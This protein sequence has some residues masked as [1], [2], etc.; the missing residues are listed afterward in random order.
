MRNRGRLTPIKEAPYKTS[1]L[2]VAITV[3]PE[4]RR[5]HQGVYPL[6]TESLVKELRAVDVPA[7]FADD[8]EHRVWHERLGDVTHELVIGVASGLMS[9]AVWEAVVQILS[10]VHGHSGKVHIRFLRQRRDS[11][12]RMSQTWFDF[13]GNPKDLSDVWKDLNDDSD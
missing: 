13:D 1:E 8:P 4:R 12:G 11:R 7:A 10:R 2:A 3:L 6:G 5:G 9:A